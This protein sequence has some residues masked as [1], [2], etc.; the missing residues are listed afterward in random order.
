MN[1][2]INEMLQF[3]LSYVLVLVIGFVLIQWLSGGFFTK[4]LKVKASR[5]KLVLVNVRSKL[6]HYFVA[7]KIEGEFLV[8]QDRE[9]RANKQKEPK[10]LAIKENN[11][12]Y[13]AYGV[14]CINVDESTNNIIAPNMS[15][16][17]GFDSLKFSNL[18]TRA[19]FKPSLDEDDTTKKIV[20]GILIVCILLILGLIV[21]YVK[22]GTIE[23]LIA[24]LNT[25]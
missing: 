5:G 3:L 11:V 1:Q 14:S 10:R 22:I 20:I 18:L 21:V 7:G 2:I 4:F 16:V 23:S 24:S 25:I 6:I 8:Y 19:L 17:P 9:S 13:R 12:F 15:V